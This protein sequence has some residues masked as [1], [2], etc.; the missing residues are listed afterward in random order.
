MNLYELINAIKQLC[1]GVPNVHTVLSGD[2]YQLN[3][4]PDLEYSAMV[5]SQD[6]HT[7]RPNDEYIDYTFNIFYVDRL[8][9]DKSNKIDI[10]NT[11][12]QTLKHISNSLDELGFYINDFETQIFEERFEALCAGAYARMVVRVNNDEC[13]NTLGSIYV[14]NDVYNA[15]LQAQK[16]LDNRQDDR[17]S[18]L[19]EIKQNKA[20]LLHC[21]GK[22]VKD[23]DG[24]VLSFIDVQNILDENNNNVIIEGI[25]R[26]YTLGYL[27]HYQEICFTSHYAYKGWAEINY[28]YFEYDGDY[29]LIGQ[30]GLA[31]NEQIWT[32]TKEKASR[33]E[34]SQYNKTDNFKTINNQSII[35]RGNIT[36]EGVYLMFDSGDEMLVDKDGNEYDFVD[37]DHLLNDGRDVKIFMNDMNH[38]ALMRINYITENAFY[39][40]QVDSKDGYVENVYLVIY[41]NGGF[42]YGDY[43][44]MTDGD[45][46]Y[47]QGQLDETQKRTTDL[48]NNVEEIK[49][50]VSSEYATITYVDEQVGNI[51]NALTLILGD[52]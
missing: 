8:T 34:L 27:D 29:L 2:V 1:E 30:N 12:I 11:A 37:I 6:T 7:V 46:S 51:S 5:I 52:E 21:D 39:F 44:L 22:T 14:T 16:S 41:R 13:G 19:D 42:E 10:E 49:N 45:L 32:L 36:I 17:L 26:T 18:T 48:E 9:E 24:N 28:I 33:F 31:T 40:S 4:N 38:G 20:V 47:L 50:I 23:K 25:G 35:G 15:H 3:S 43:Q